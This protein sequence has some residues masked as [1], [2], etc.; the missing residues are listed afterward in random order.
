[1]KIIDQTP[2]FQETGQLSLLDR[3]KAILRFGPNWFKEIDAEK[4][5]IAVLDKTLDKKYTLLHNVTPYGLEA[6][7]PLI[8]VGPPGVYVMSVTNLF[9][10]F[11]AKGDQWGVLSGDTFK[12]DNPNL[13]TRTERMARA[14]QVLLQRQGFVDI[15]SVEAILLCSNPTFHV[16]SMRPIIRVVMRDVL[17]RFGVSIAQ[18]RVVLSPETINNIV[19]RIM[20]PPAPPPAKIVEAAAAGEPATA[21]AEEAFQA[22]ADNPNVP[23]FALPGSEPAPAFN[24]TP[25]EDVEEYPAPAANPIRRLRL[26]RK[27]WMM[28]AGMVLIWLIIVAIFAFLIVKDLLL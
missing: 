5:V 26:S 11:R 2:F 4:S 20:N 10:T 23:A 13:L 25:F 12:P 27:Q 9:G 15:T 16:D 22:E 8:L 18:A 19:A 24:E 1:M 7:I 3:A 14:I 28:L 21:G 6:M 17:E